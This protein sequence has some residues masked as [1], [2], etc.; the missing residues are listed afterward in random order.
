MIYR[1]LITAKIAR[2]KKEDSK[3]DKIIR[4]EVYQV[5]RFHSQCSLVRAYTCDD[6]A[7][8]VCCPEY[9]GQFNNSITK[10]S[11]I[12]YAVDWETVVIRSKSNDDIWTASE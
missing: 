1:D 11:S 8:M 2:E 10:K 6:K 9:I 12:V 4:L 3:V 7:E 5:Y